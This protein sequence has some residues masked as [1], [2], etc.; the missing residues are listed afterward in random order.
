MPKQAVLAPQP[1][2][3]IRAFRQSQ[4]RIFNYRDFWGA[5][6]WTKLRC[7]SD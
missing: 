4:R 6:L 2:E 3:N 5:W 1:I 7:C